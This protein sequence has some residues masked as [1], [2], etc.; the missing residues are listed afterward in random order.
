MK[1]A[2]LGAGAIGGLLAAN[3]TRAG[4]PVTIIDQGQHLD[5]C[6]RTSKG[7]LQL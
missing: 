4:H 1:I 3:L 2:I 7:C 6:G 5:F